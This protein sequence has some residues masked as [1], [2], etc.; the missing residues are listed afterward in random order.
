[1]LYSALF[2]ALG[3]AS[4]PG[5]LLLAALFAAVLPELF[6]YLELFRG[7]EHGSVDDIACKEKPDLVVGVDEEVAGHAQD[8]D[9]AHNLQVATHFQNLAQTVV[10]RRADGQLLL[11]LRLQLL[12][13]L[14]LYAGLHDLLEQVRPDAEVV[15]LNSDGALLVK[16]AEFLGETEVDFELDGN[17][18]AETELGLDA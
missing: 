10:L 11:D 5:C 1:M 8:L 2:L 6:D 13:A 18:S 7:F 3:P 14:L 17:V 9:G 15:V 12:L 4:E 16:D